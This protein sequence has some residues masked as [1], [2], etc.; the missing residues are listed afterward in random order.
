MAE[1]GADDPVVSK[2]E[3]NLRAAQIKWVISP[4]HE[5]NPIPLKR[6]YRFPWRLITSH[7]A[8]IDCREKWSIALSTRAA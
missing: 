6:N 5:V 1:L 4:H 7:L 2:A 8:E 3:A